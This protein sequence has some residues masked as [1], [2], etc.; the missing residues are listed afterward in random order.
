MPN[1]V[2]IRRA[3]ALNRETGRITT[4]PMKRNIYASRIKKA[5]SLLRAAGRDEALVLSCAPHAVRSRDVHFP[6]R[7]NSDL[8]Y[9]TGSHHPDLQLVMR[10]QAKEKLVLVAPPRDP[11]VAVFEGDTPPL[12]PLARSIGASIRVSKDPYSTVRELLKGAEVAHLQSVPGTISAEIRREL[13]TVSPV[14]RSSAHLPPRVVEAELLTASLRCIKDAGEVAAIEQA[15]RLTSATLLHVAQYIRRGVREREIAVLIDYLYRANDADSAF[16]PIVASGCSA[17]T[18][19]YH[20]MTRTLRSG[21]MLLIDTGCELNMYACD[22]T[23]TIPVDGTTTPELEAVYEIVLSAQ[24]AAIKRIKPGVHISAVFKAA[25]TELTLGLKEL[26][27]LRG[28]LS[29]LLA[30]G[31]FKPWFPHGIG[32]SIGIDVHD[33]SPNPGE[34]LGILQPGMV[35][36]IEPGLYFKKK[37]AQI[38]ACGVRIEDEVLVT[39]KGHRVLTEDVF[40]KELDVVC[41]LLNSQ[42]LQ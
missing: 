6:Y 27:V 19:H 32:H 1:V 20:A 38:P 9:F 33:V 41:D 4:H 39:S 37:V 14:S 17:A 24:R 8:F 16:M 11:I 30:K 36:T 28:K 5:F 26:G 29:S 40:P 31:A 23:R 18:L 10:P 21:E 22:I 35:I 34:R 42:G 7:Q 12:G 13:S 2:A 3:S 15:A 25:A